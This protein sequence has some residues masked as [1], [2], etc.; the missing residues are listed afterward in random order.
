MCDQRVVKVG[1][2]KSQ[3]ALVQTNCVV[4]R[5]RRLYP[6]TRFEII[7]M[8]T[9][10]DQILDQPLA[11][12]GEKS[13]F[14]KELEIAL[15]DLKVDLVVHS[16][17]DL[18]STLPAGMAIGAVI[19]RDSPYDVVVF[20]K[21]VRQQQ[22]QGGDG[23]SMT[24]DMLPAGST[25]G[26]SSL[27]RIAQL[28]RRYPHLKF[29]DVRG[30]LNTRLRKVDDENGLYDALILAE[31]GLDRLE[32]HD[33]I[34]QVLSPDDCMYAVSQGAMAV[35]CRSFDIETLDMLSPLHDRDTLLRVVAERALLRS[36]EGGCSVPVACHT[37]VLDGGC[38]LRM[39]G[40]VFSLDGADARVVARDMLVRVPPPH[41]VAA[42]DAA[43]N[44]AGGGDDEHDGPTA[45]KKSKLCPFRPSGDRDA[46]AAEPSVPAVTAEHVAN[47]VDLERKVAGAGKCPYFSG[48]IARHIPHEEMVAAE[49]LGLDIAD[50]LRTQG[51]AE[52]LRRAREEN[53]RI[54]LVMEDEMRRKRE[55][56][57]RAHDP[58]SLPGHPPVLSHRSLS[59]EG[60]AATAAATGTSAGNGAAL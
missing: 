55:F 46:A 45:A 23:P 11:H 1:S 2:R 54:R 7:T 56:A 39:R 24:L 26:T 47:N 13:L 19:K 8:S 16:L 60:S 49:Q 34:D 10:G 41:P 43:A 38:R 25:V 53:Q 37:E 12:I 35:E 18:P 30:N 31:A 48:I 29:H 52:I 58:E 51:G 4:E 40:G 28:K 14:T 3:L 50:E 6:D 27:R 42:G 44:G 22:L 15:E 9:T 20:S 36:L 32:W 21:R 5:L 33:R 59:R 57:L 17:K